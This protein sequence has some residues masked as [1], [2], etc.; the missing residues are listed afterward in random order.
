MC[1]NGLNAE[2]EALL[3]QLELPEGISVK[4]IIKVLEGLTI[5][6]TD[7]FEKRF[8]EDMINST[9]NALKNMVK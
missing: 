8:N 4:E 9:I 7:C 1:I 6:D 2:H 3:E 5:E